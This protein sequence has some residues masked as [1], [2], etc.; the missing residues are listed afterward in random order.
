M[1]L[2]QV[3]AFVDESIA[4]GQRW[5]FINVLGG[6][7][8]LHPDFQEIVRVLLHDYVDAFSAETIVQ[9]TSNGYGAVARRRLDELPAHP[10]LIVNR[11]S[12]KDD[13]RVPHFTPVQRR[14]RRRSRVRRRGLP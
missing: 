9:V 14:P 4:L 1:R 8:T 12:F 13:A 3:Q 6:E 7:P 10:R 5:E 2:D 11:D